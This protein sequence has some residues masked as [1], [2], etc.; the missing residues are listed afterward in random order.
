MAKMT[1]RNKVVHRAI[2]ILFPSAVSVNVMNVKSPALGT[3][4]TSVRISFENDVSVSSKSSFV[5]LII[6]KYFNFVLYLF[7]MLSALCLP[8][9]MFDWVCQHSFVVSN[10]S[11]YTSS[12]IFPVVLLGPFFTIFSCFFF[13]FKR[14]GSINTAITHLCQKYS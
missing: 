6:I 1:E 14:H 11:V 10:Y 8:F 7:A 4:S 2:R 9:F 5:R 3:N 13:I 12:A